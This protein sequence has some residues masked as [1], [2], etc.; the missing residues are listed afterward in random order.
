MAATIRLKPKS[1]KALKELAH[2]TGE[3]MQEALDRAIEERR[4]RVYLE[5]LNADY[6]ALRKDPKAV[7]ELQREQELWD[8]T[9]NDGLEDA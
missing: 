4:R 6:A 8:R 2:I 7:A 3:S 9:S 1:H 5:G